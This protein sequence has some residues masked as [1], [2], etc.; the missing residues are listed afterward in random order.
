MDLDLKNYNQ[1]PNHILNLVLKMKQ[2][3]KNLKNI[4]QVHLIE[5]YMLFNIVNL[6]NSFHPI[7]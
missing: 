2:Q 5:I 7:M 1:D 4:N 6:L 3:I